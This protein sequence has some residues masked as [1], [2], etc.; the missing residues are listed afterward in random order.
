[1]PKNPT[2]QLGTTIWLAAM[3]GALALSLTVIP[4]LLENTPQPI[5]TGMAIAA[6]IAQTAILLALAAWAGAALSRPL[7]LGAPVFEAMLSGTSAWPAVKRQIAPA[8][9]GGGLVGAALL[10]LVRVAPSELAVLAQEIEIP[11]IAKLL[12]GGVTE[13]VLMRWGLMTVL[14]WLPWRWMQKRAGL[15][16]RSYVISAIVASA[17]LFGALHLPAVVA[18]GASLTPATVTFIIVGN[19]LPGILF[20]L[21][22]WRHGLEAAIVAHALSHGVYT[23]AS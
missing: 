3:T 11:V 22:Y 5:P 21:L 2:L 18:M 7:G 14:I 20:G 10:V 16:R 13:E 19:T 12:Y 1:M 8:A 15:P 9:I 6:S 4:Q 23:L 17:S